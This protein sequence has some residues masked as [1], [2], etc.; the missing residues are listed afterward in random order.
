MEPQTQKCRRINCNGA[1]V[2][3]CPLFYFSHHFFTSVFTKL[4]V[5]TAKATIKNISIIFQNIPIT[6]IFLSRNIIP[7]VAASS[8]SPSPIVYTLSLIKRRRSC[9]EHVHYSP[10]APIQLPIIPHVMPQQN[11]TSIT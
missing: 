1:L 6:G 7:I 2:V 5:S 11:K 3:I 9:K 4:A 8:H 10:T